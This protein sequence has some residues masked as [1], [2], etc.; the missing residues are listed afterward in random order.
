MEVRKLSG[1]PKKISHI[2]KY[3]ETFDTAD[4]NS[5]TKSDLHGSIEIELYNYISPLVSYKIYILFSLVL[6]N[7]MEQSLLH[8]QGKFNT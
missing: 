6:Q 7:F 8:A 4:R 2:G 1:T 5:I 3:Y